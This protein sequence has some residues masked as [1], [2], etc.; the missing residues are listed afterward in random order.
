MGLIVTDLGKFLNKFYNMK[1]KNLKTELANL[2]ISTKPDNSIDTCE[3]KKIQIWGQVIPKVQQDDDVRA[4]VE[5]RDLPAQ[6]KREI[7]RAL[8]TSQTQT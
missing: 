5:R 4:E 7:R 1:I 6:G 8:S 3:P 2:E